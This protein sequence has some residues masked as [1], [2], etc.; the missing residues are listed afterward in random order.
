[1][2]LF[3]L[4][5]TCSQLAH[6]QS[7]VACSSWLLFNSYLPQNN[8]WLS[9]C[10]YYCNYNIPQ[11]S[12]LISY[13]HNRFP[14]CYDWAGN[15]FSSVYPHDK[16][17]HKPIVLSII[18]FQCK[19]II[20][21]KRERERETERNENLSEVICEAQWLGEFGMKFDTQIASWAS[22]GWWQVGYGWIYTCFAYVI[23]RLISRYFVEM[24]W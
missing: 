3:F 7:Q 24:L 18:S 10:M 11:F 21:W 4:Y 1:M 2:K 5:F 9:N 23:S 14:S 6:L 20:A 22:P 12:N 17:I 16:E 19:N 8:L 15:N 13:F